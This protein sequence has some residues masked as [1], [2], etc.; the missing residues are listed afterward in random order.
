MPVAVVLLVMMKIEV[1]IVQDDLIKMSHDEYGLPGR[2]KGPSDVL[3]LALLAL[4]RQ[5]ELGRDV[6]CSW[7]PRA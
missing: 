5:D 3:M 6:I 4:Y 7:N 2:I 1:L